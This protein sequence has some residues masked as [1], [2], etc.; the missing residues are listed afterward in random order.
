V[1]I[2][3]IA[4]QRIRLSRTVEIWEIAPPRN[5]III[6]NLLVANPVSTKWTYTNDRPVVTYYKY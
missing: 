3:D 6:K 5:D 1:E 2:W 4:P